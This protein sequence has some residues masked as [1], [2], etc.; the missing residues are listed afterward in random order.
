MNFVS[1]PRGLEG[2]PNLTGVDAKLGAFDGAAM[3]FT[4]MLATRDL[5]E[6][7]F[8]KT[9][10]S[11]GESEKSA[12]SAV[13]FGFDG[14]PLGPELD[15][16]T[17]EFTGRVACPMP[18][19]SASEAFRFGFDLGKALS[20]LFDAQIGSDGL[21]TCAFRLTFTLSLG[22]TE[23]SESRQLKLDCVSCILVVIGFT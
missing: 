21:F 17:R 14:L 2:S 15:L 9:Q 23:G 7:A 19:S 3:L 18:V 8:R 13:G 5:G 16:G 10:S 20:A 22:A 1:P 12:K 11:E 6:A 4:A